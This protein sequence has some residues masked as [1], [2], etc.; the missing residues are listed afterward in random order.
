MPLYTYIDTNANIRT[1]TWSDGCDCLVENLSGHAAGGAHALQ[2]FALK[3]RYD[4]I[5][6]VYCVI[7]RAS[8]TTRNS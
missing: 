1:R 6:A 5:T 3:H 7:F 4:T 2:I 8:V